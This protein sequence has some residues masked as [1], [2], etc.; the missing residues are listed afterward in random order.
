MGKKKRTIRENIDDMPS[1]LK[2]VKGVIRIDEPIEDYIRRN[3]LI[4]AED[5]WKRLN[6]L[7]CDSDK[8]HDL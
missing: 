8:K 5:S 3:R 4:S 6:K 7:M 2:G 1:F